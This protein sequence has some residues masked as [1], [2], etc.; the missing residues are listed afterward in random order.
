M[1]RWQQIDALFQAALERDP[2]ERDVWLREPAKAT[3]ITA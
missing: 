1:E 2:P 3:P